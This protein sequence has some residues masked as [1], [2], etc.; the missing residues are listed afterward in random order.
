MIQ[1]ESN[2]QPRAGRRSSS[3]LEIRFEFVDGSKEIFVQTDPE[4]AEI[5]E[6]GVNGSNLSYLNLQNLIGYT[7]YPG[8]AE[9][10]ADSWIAQPK[11]AP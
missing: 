11:R 9:I 6:R 5:I 3:A 1:I 8:A 4:Q 7:V 10:P 2:R